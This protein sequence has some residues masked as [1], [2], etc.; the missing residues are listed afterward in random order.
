MGVE[1]DM[2]VCNF[3]LSLFGVFR[4]SNGITFKLSEVFNAGPVKNGQFLVFFKPTGGEC[5]SIPEKD[6]PRFTAALRKHL[7]Y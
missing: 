3:I 6:K 2:F 7:G 1:V 4:A 5:V